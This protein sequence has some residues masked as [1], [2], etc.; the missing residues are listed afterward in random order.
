MTTAVVIDQIANDLEA[1]GFDIV[2]ADDAGLDVVSNDGVPFR[3]EV[4]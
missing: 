3:I 4:Y 2:V 1:R